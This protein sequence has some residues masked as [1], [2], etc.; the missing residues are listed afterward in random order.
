[1]AAI[2]ATIADDDTISM[3]TSALF[4]IVISAALNV[5]VDRKE[6]RKEDLNTRAGY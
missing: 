4:S 5:C 3:G 1:M 2:K 6:G